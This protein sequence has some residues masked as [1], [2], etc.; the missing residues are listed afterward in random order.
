MFRWRGLDPCVFR[1][2]GL[3]PLQ[4]GLDPLYGRIGED[5]GLQLRMWSTPRHQ[6]AR[7]N[8]SEPDA[9]QIEMAFGLRYNEGRS[10]CFA[11]GL[12]RI[13]QIPT[14][15]YY[16][17]QHCLYA[18][19]GAREKPNKQ[20]SGPSLDAALCKTHK[21]TNKS[22]STQQTRASKTHQRI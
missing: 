12:H 10:P 20:A 17:A 15:V 8:M 3:D 16:D 21:Q 4:R 2:R 7:E 11:A 5:V 19:G 1:W 18:S 22:T 13:M 14:C 9:R 6:T